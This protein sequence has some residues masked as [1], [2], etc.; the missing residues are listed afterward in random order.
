MRMKHWWTDSGRGK[1]E[2]LGQRRLSLF[3]FFRGRKKLAQRR[4]R[5][6]RVLKKTCECQKTTNKEI[7]LISKR[8][9]IRREQDESEENT[10]K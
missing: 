4:A 6:G 2:V 10:K 3:D 7:T 5:R 1:T 8:L 9:N